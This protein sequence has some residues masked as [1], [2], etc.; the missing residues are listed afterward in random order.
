[1][2]NLRFLGLLSLITATSVLAGCFDKDSSPTSE[3]TSGSEEEQGIQS[4]VFEEMADFADPDVRTYYGDGETPPA[5]PINTHTWRRELLSLDKT[6]NITIE[7]PSGAPA[8]ADV[9]VTGY[10]TGLLHLWACADSCL[11]HCTKDFADTGV[12]SLYFEKVRPTVRPHRG[13]RLLAMSGVKIESEATTRQINSV[14]VESEGVDETFTTVEELVRLQDIL[15][16]PPRSEVTVTVDTGDETDHVFLH[17]RRARMRFELANNGDGTFTGTYVTG[18]APG[19]RHAVVDVLSDGT[20]MDDE[21][22]Y[23]NMAWGIPYVIE[24]FDIE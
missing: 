10:A 2:R 13:W 11:E 17:I 4:V 18:V 24:P 21:E 8:T 1:M 19:P 3:S 9:L 23:D 15:R 14:R 22:P 7:N 20:L 16:L 6:I 12:R 5:S